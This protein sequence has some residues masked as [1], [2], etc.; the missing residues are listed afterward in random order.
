VAVRAGQHRLGDVPAGVV[1]QC[2][3]WPT[4]A[5]SVAVLLAGAASCLLLRRHPSAV[6]DGPPATATRPAAEPVTTTADWQLDPFRFL[7]YAEPSGAQIGPA[8]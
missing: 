3:R 2:N 1:D 8:Q 6:P 7:I 5:I 4:L